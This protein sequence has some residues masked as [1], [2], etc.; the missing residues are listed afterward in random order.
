[1]LDNALIKS[2]I[3]ALN[4]PRVEQR[5]ESSCEP[6]TTVESSVPLS[7][8]NSK[9][10]CQGM[11]WQRS[12]VDPV[13]NKS[14]ASNKAEQSEPPPAPP[15][16]IILCQRGSET[17]QVQA[18]GQTRPHDTEIAECVGVHP[19]DNGDDSVRPCGDDAMNRDL[20][21]YQDHLNDWHYGGADLAQAV[22]KIRNWSA[23]LWPRFVPAEWK[24]QAVVQPQI[25]FRFYRDGTA[26]LGH[27]HRGRNDAGLRWEV[28]INPRHLQHRSEAQ[29]ASTVLHELLH[30]FE[31]I[32]GTMP[33]SRNNYHSA[34]FRR[35]AK[36]L[37]IPCTTYGHDLGI[38][39]P[40]PFAVWA[41]ERGLSFESEMLA[42]A[43]AV[44]EVHVRPKRAAW[45]CDCPQDQLVVVLVAAGA[46]LR[47]RC[48]RC[49]AE[50][51]RR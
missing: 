16:G 3:D 38:A 27:Y 7:P 43:S 20:A 47:A 41:H 22:T 5:K 36:F 24:G 23:E 50:Y 32:T 17:L 28:S 30:C 2:T 37:G 10:P 11:L 45:I 15:A 26:V 40:S 46:E 35:H 48:G 51:R 44:N 19:I 4:D 9:T 8:S 1:M 49:G 14:A 33:K 42:T 34:W 31:D 18:A 39:D 29:V 6:C 12:I 21:A 25:L 13:G